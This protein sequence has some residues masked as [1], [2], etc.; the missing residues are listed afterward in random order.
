MLRQ[1]WWKILSVLLLIYTFIAG[2]TI[3]VPMI[4]NLYATIRNLFFHVP[5]WF[6]MMIVFITSVVY[7]VKYLRSPSLNT[8]IYSANYAKTGIVYGILGLV[9][10]AIWAKYAWGEYWSN[11][12]KQIGA[13]IALLI[14]AAYFVLRNSI[15][16]IDKRAKIAA[17]YNI[18]AFAILVPT[19]WILPRMVESLHPG[20]QGVEGNPGINGNDLDPAMRKVFWPAVIGWTLFGVWITT[21]KIRYE[22]LKEKQLANG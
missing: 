20:G 7:A 4:G 12:P 1:S 10:G 18:F 5:M 15:P 21:L 19:I 13:A 9:T 11:D 22:L 6:G 16:D 2:F 3:K 8:D 17:V 14:Y